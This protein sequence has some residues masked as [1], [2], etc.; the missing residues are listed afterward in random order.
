MV[1][2][3]GCDW[4]TNGLPSTSCSAPL[5]ICSATAAVIMPVSCSMLDVIDAIGEETKKPG[6]SPALASHV[7]LVQTESRAGDLIERDRQL[8]QRRAE[9]AR[10]KLAEPGSGGVV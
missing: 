7:N 8:I 5:S 1:K 2:K 3:V 9:T 10:M 4:C 6:G